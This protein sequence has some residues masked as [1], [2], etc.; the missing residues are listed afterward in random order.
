MQERWLLDKQEDSRHA[1]TI[2]DYPPVASPFLAISSSPTNYNHQ[3]PAKPWE[4]ST[5]ATM[6]DENQFDSV[7]WQREDLQQAQEPVPTAIPQETTLP[8]RSASGRRNTNTSDEPQ[9]GEH[10]DGVD[11]VG[12]GDG[13]LECTVEKP[14]KEND[15][16]KDAYVS[17]LV[18]T[19]V[20]CVMYCPGPANTR[21]D[22][23]QVLPKIRIL[24]TAAFHRLRF[25]PTNATSRISSMR[26]PTPP[27][28]AHH[29][30]HPRRPLQHRVHPTPSMVPPPLHQTPDPPPR[31]P[32]LHNPNPLPRNKRLERTDAAAA[33]QK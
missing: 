25:P 8:T 28:K 1:P 30:L 14:L 11:L 16:T 2:L 24:R 22:R 3:A 6:E 15:G 26:R 12:V 10:A 9:A 31:P 27:R 20:C 18:T 5:A 33:Q 13:I 19:N 4:R 17:Y 21:L 32:P 23:L 7:S 29:C